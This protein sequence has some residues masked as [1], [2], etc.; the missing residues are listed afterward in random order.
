MVGVDDELCLVDSPP[1]HEVS[2]VAFVF[3]HGLE[4]V[5]G[6]GAGGQGLVAAFGVKL[7]VKVADFHSLVGVLASGFPDVWGRQGETLGVNCLTL[8]LL[9]RLKNK[10]RVEIMKSWA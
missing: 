9:G 8:T 2:T 1:G 10:L 4:V 3:P 7:L 5:K 6:G